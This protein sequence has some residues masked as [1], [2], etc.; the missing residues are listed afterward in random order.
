MKVC[1]N[2]LFSQTEEEVT[3]RSLENTAVAILRDCSLKVNQKNGKEVQAAFKKDPSHL[4][5]YGFQIDQYDKTQDLIIDPLIL[6]FSSFIGGKASDTSRR[7]AVDN[8][9]NIYVVGGSNSPDFQTQNANM[10]LKGSYSDVILVKIDS[11]GNLVYSTYYGGSGYDYALDLEV[12]G[13]EAYITGSTESADLPMENAINATYSNTPSD[14]FVAGFNST[15]TGLLFSTYLGGNGHEMGWGITIDGDGIYIVGQTTSM[16]FPIQNAFQSTFGGGSDDGFI[17]H[18]SPDG[19]TLISSSYFGGFGVDP[20]LEIVTTHSKQLFTTGWTSSTNL[21]YATNDHNGDID[22]FVTLFSHSGGAMSVGWTTYIG[23][24][25]KDGAYGINIRGG[26]ITSDVCITGETE[27]NDFPLVNPYQDVHGGDY[28]AFLTVVSAWSGEITYSTFLGGSG[29]EVGRDIVLTPNN[30]LI[31]GGHTESSNFPVF[32]AY[33]SAYNGGEYD[34]FI[35]GFKNS[36]L[37][38]AFS[39]YFGSSGWDRLQ[40]VN[41]NA[42]GD[43]YVCGHTDSSSFP[44]LNAFNDTF[45]GNIDL[46][47]SKFLTNDTPS[48]DVSPVIV[49]QDPLEGAILR[50][51]SIIDFSISDG[52]S[53]LRQVLYHWDNRQNNTFTSPFTIFAPEKEG[54]HTIYVYAQD[55]EGNWASSNFD[56]TIDNTGPTV[57]VSGLTDLTTIRGTVI[58]TA[59]VS[60]TNGMDEVRFILDNTTLTNDTAPPYNMKWNSRSVRDGSYTF[61][62]TAIDIAGNVYTLTFSI[63]VKN[64][65]EIDIGLMFG[66]VAAL[67]V[68]GGGI[69]YWR[70]Y[71]FRNRRII[72]LYLKSDPPK[73]LHEIADETRKTVREVQLVLQKANKFV[74]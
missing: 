40:S 15:G 48:D 27:S 22:A 68:P 57:S 28:D 21:P 44:T 51:G 2:I 1:G 31:I 53:G 52:N 20:I 35:T 42:H 13:E 39:T 10:S 70:S 3:I 5:S 63:N 32:N 58:I 4:N 65:I 45:G 38:L 41:C 34:G 30:T 7:L 25:E 73:S 14:A 12:V 11:D 64:A 54:L 18:L 37:S 36:G 29:Y 60:D 19:Q 71:G 33:S 69:I 61:L 62:V 55:I 26:G 24:T 43:L 72:N 9:G 50:S 46:Y 56:F 47:I 74:K 6:G 8:N 17:T 66:V 67:V 59:T 23:G 49:L 16:D